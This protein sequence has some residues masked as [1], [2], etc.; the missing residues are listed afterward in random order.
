MSGVEITVSR[1]WNAEGI[2]V[3]ISKEGVSA[4]MG[5]DR[6]VIALKEEVILPPLKFQSKKAKLK[7]EEALKTSIETAIQRIVEKMKAETASVAHR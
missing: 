2:D 4:K 7:K 5:I 6:L 3:C 1:A